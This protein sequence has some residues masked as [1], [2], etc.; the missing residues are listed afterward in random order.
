MFE[1][2]YWYASELRSREWHYCYS[3]YHLPSHTWMCIRTICHIKLAIITSPIL[4]I[5]Q[6]PTSQTCKLWVLATLHYVHS[7]VTLFK[8]SLCIFVIQH[9]GYCC[10]ISICSWY[11]QVN[12]SIFMKIISHIIIRMSSMNSLT[13]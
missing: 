12:I 1:K 2:I 3:S 13:S 5:T 6:H 10:I 11:L 4:I 7:K 9:Y 8:E